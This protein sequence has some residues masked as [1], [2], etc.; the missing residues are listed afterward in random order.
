MP[1]VC[2]VPPSQ[3][4]KELQSVR[5]RR[6]LKD[7]LPNPLVTTIGGTNS[8]LT[9]ARNIF[10]TAAD[11]ESLLT[12]NPSQVA[13][14]SLDLGIP[15]IVGATVSLPPGE[16][17]A[18]LTRSHG[19]EGDENN[20]RKTRRGKRK[21]GDR[22]RRR[23]RREARDMAEQARAAQFFDLVVRRKAVSQPMDSFSSWLESQRRNTTGPSGRTIQDLEST[24]PPLSGE[25]ASFRGYVTVR[26]ACES[27]MDNFYNNTNY[28]KHR[29]DAKVCRKE[30]LRMG[31]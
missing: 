5:Y 7:N 1:P 26:R 30:E 16:T 24:L 21:S 2:R 22:K 14:L 19:K 9:E 4:V 6:V 13:V 20:K 17:P 29:W 10:K 15:C 3:Q 23:A 12:A 18:A 25:C 8:F 27:Y 31:Y 28:W 11:V